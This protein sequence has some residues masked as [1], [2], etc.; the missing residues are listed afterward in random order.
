LKI[1]Y[2]I[3]ITKADGCLL[4]SVPDLQIDTSG[5][6]IVEAIEMARDAISIWCVSEQDDFKRALPE[7]SAQT[8]IE[9]EPDDI[10]TLVDIDLDA[11]RRSIENKAIKKTLTIP[12]WLNDRAEKA[13]INFSQTL[14]KALKDEL[15]IAE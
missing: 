12:S 6:N 11:Y 4:V 8:A 7:P 5:Q 9:H 2:P 3:V 1:A 14:Q 10:V 13:R 15:H